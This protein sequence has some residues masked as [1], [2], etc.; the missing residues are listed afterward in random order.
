MRKHT[1]HKVL[2]ILDNA[3]GHSTAFGRN[4]IQVVFFPPNVT[5]W[6]QP[7][8]M[9]IIAAIKKRYKFLL[10]KEMNA[11]HDT[12]QHLKDQ[13]SLAIKRMKR[14]ATE[15][16]YG[17]PPHLLDVENLVNLAWNEI[18]SQSLKNCF[19]KEVTFH[20]FKQAMKAML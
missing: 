9:G 2:L 15:L 6:K 12:P 8:D 13:L 5:S 4:G 16:V 14:G 10:I 1:G 19:K 20:P 18:S 7:M 11:Y 3:P 17:R